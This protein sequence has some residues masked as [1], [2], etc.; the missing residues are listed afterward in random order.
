MLRVSKLI[1]PTRLS[2]TASKWLRFSTDTAT[3]VVVGSPF[4][5]EGLS[6]QGV[7][8]PTSFPEFMLNS[9]AE[10]NPSDVAIV[11]GATNEELTFGD[12]YNS[13]HSFAHNLKGK[14]GIKKDSAVA[15]YAP[16]NIHYFTAFAGVGLTG[17]MSVPINSHY[18]VEEVD[19][20]LDVV[21]ANLIIAHPDCL[22]KAL[23]CAA[24]KGIPVLSFG[25]KSEKGAIAVDGL[26]NTP[27]NE[28]GPFDP[29]DPTSLMCCPFSSGTTG[30]PKGVMLTH[31][32]LVA[33][34]LQSMPTIG[35]SLLTSQSGQRGSLLVPLPF[36][37]IYGLIMLCIPL[38][39]GAKMVFMPAFNLQ[40]FLEL[41][42]THR[43]IKACVVPP[44]VL[45]L[46]KDPM[47]DKYDLS[48]LITMVCGAAPL[49]AAVQLQASKRLNVAIKQSWGMTELSPVG[50]MIG[51]PEGDLSVEDF[52]KQNQG[53]AGHLIPNTYA[54]IIDS[55]TREDLQCEQE[56]DLLIKGPQ[57]MK[58][59]YNNP[60]ATAETFQ[61]EWLIT[62]DIGRF[63]AEGKLYITDRSKELIKYKGFQVAPAELEALVGSMDKVKDVIVIP[64]LDEAA[65]EIPRAYVV[66]QPNGQ[67]LTEQ[68]VQEYVAERVVFYKK[69]RGGVRFVDEVPKSASGKLLRRIQITRDRETAAM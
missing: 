66:K 43:I 5:V 61:D 45:Q 21:N 23:T 46:A 34:I 62:G 26:L 29:V 48:S 31:N 69:L 17:A 35:N 1:K 12:M 60:K 27:P 19:Y 28:V 59:Y 11:D 39:S 52:V 57:V 13:I 3:K 16:N 9:I 32:N 15:I 22:D 24:K 14:F 33:N 64:V 67:D 51:D 42:E 6:D 25:S 4:R 53:A 58:G 40:R 63:D 20:Q 49:G 10:K 8:K 7:L 30:K 2:L 44:I 38:Y 54:K 36:F 56:G 47:V 18:T 55:K 50:V 65:G 68:E 41:I 37:H